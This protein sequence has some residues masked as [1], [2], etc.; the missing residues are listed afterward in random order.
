MTEWKSV[1]TAQSKTAA[2]NTKGSVIART[3]Q[4]FQNDYMEINA[5]SAT[6]FTT[7]GSTYSRRQHEA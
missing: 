6:N 4:V 5:S 7:D 3:R 1:P 2:V